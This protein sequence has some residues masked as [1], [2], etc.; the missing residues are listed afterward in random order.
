M[1]N[2]L[3]ILGKI[4]WC[5]LPIFSFLSDEDWSIKLENAIDCK[6]CQPQIN[7]RFLPLG[8]IVLQMHIYICKICS[9]GSLR[10]INIETGIFF[11]IVVC[12]VTG[13]LAL[14]IKVLVHTPVHRNPCLGTL[15][16]QSYKLRRQK[17]PGHVNRSLCSHN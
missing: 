11:I 3:S 17:M 15:R 16:L 13:S 2:N 12:A 10:D 8:W 4:R 6:C 7:L 9:L 14:E 1:S 5:S